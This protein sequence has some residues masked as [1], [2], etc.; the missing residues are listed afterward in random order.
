MLADTKLYALV[1]PAAILAIA[2]GN[3]LSD[4]YVLR[5][6]QFSSMRSNCVSFDRSRSR[7]AWLHPAPYLYCLAL[8]ATSAAC[9]VGESDTCANTLP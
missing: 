8:T 7:I 9:L 4:Q 3:K 2:F 1:V 5:T 6:G